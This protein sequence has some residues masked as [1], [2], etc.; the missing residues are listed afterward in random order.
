MIYGTIRKLIY[1]PTERL[2]MIDWRRFRRIDDAS[3]KP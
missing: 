3:K 1:E 2:L